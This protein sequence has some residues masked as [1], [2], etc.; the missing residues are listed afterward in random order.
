VDRRFAFDTT[1]LVAA[2]PEEV[3]D[4][5]VDLEHYPAWWPEVRAVAKVGEDDA[6]VLCRSVLPYTLELR[7]HAVSRE[8]PTLRVEVSGDLRGSVAWT[9][10]DDGAGGTRIKASQEVALVPFPTVVV[11]AARPVLVW[12]H[13]R[14]MRGCAAGLSARLSG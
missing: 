12:N 5:L 9:L 7:L 8:L 11:A 2:S 13:H 4:V 10:S 6:I 3:R 1:W 14:M